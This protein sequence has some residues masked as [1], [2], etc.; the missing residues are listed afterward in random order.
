MPTIDRIGNEFVVNTSSVS[1]ST[2]SV[3]NLADGR[4]MVTWVDRDTVPGSQFLHKVHGQ[5]FNGDGSKS[6]SEFSTAAPTREDY[7]GV[8]GL[9]DGHFLVTWGKGT[10]DIFQPS[11]IVGQVFNADGTAFGAE[12]S[13][14]STPSKYEYLPQ[15]PF[16]LAGAL[17][18]PGKEAP[19]ITKPTA[20]SSMPMA[21]SSG[22]SSC[23]TLIIR[24]QAS[25]RWPTGVSS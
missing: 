11:D 7:T 23:R 25:P 13:I 19:A 4:F 10:S 17:R 14:T 8:A 16:S 5:A 2:P 12:F 9:T 18:S 3:G 15:S 1:D 22:Q 20:R 24:G 21:V 6:G